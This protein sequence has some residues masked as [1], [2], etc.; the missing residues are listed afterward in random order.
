MISRVSV[1]SVKGL[2]TGCCDHGNEPSGYV[3]KHGEFDAQ[4]SNF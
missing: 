3:L 4:L 1:N 2:T